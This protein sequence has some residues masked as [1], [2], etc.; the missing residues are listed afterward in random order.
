M[1]GLFDRVMAGQLDLTM[2]GIP[3]LLFGAIVGYVASTKKGFSPA[4]GLIGGALLGILSPVM[5][6][7]S[8]TG[9]GDNRKKCPA[10]AEWVLLEAKICKHC[11]TEL[12]PPS[13]E[14]TKVRAEPS[15]TSDMF[16]G[17]G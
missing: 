14:P 8:T 16:G 15:I 1:D 4:A 9:L 3:W 17:M 7:M 11:R 2:L 10:C 5:F 12:P 6:A 13:T